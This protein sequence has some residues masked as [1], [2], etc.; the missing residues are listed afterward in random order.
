MLTHWLRSTAAACMLTGLCC[1]L[2]AQEPDDAAAGRA[3]SGERRA[4][5]PAGN[6]FYIGL[7]LDELSEQLRTQLKLE[8]GVIVADVFPESPAAKAEIRKHDILLKVGEVAVRSP[9]DVLKAVGE[10]QNKELSLLVLREGKELTVVVTPAKRPPTARLPVG[11]DGAGREGRLRWPLPRGEG[12]EPFFL[13]Q[14]GVMMGKGMLK[15]G[16]LPQD[17]SISVQKSGKEPARIVVKKGDKTWEVAESKL[18]DLPGEVREVVERFLAGGLPERMA[19]RFQGQPGMP[20]M[21]PGPPA[22]VQEAIKR[23]QAD[24]AKAEEKLKEQVRKWHEQQQRTGDPSRGAPR[25]GDTERKLD[26]V[27]EALKN[28]R[29]EVDE[30]KKK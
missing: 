24:V 23:A 14:P 20:R 19:F 30:L 17:M 15:F 26:E 4:E 6:S 8:H 13:F 3:E 9:H 25:P 16:E 2:L 28:L 11:V 21:P 18:S 29:Q 12:H 22:E 5:E 27:L 7:G 1:S 10:A